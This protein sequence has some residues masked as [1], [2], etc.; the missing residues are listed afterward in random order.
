MSFKSSLAV[1]LLSLLGCVAPD[2]GEIS[3]A[4]QEVK[5]APG[6]L[7]P[8]DGYFPSAP[9]TDEGGCRHLACCSRY[10]Q[11]AD[12]N[13]I[14]YSCAAVSSCDVPKHKQKGTWV[15]LFFCGRTSDCSDNDLWISLPFSSKDVRSLCGS[16]VVICRDGKK[17]TATVK[18]KSN[19][20]GNGLL[21][22][23]SPAVSAVLGGTA[24]SKI[25]LDQNDPRIDEDDACTGPG[26][27]GTWVNGDQAFG[28]CDDGRLV[29]S[30]PSLTAIWCNGRYAT[31]GSFSVNCDESSPGGSHTS[32]GTCELAAQ[33]VNCPYTSNTNGNSYV[34]VGTKSMTDVCVK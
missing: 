4:E 17:T 2:V 8:G 33:S 32:S 29:V 26:L 11:K 20:D 7:T 31:D 27:R 6:Q 12:D 30:D 19:N 34:F 15:P 14:G 18:D 24:G 23:V 21:F 10:G 25:Y 16:D 3:V 22:E 28:F 9:V 1:L 13:D 5:G